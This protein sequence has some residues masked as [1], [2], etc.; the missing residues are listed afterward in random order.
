MRR[1]APKNVVRLALLP[2]LGCLVLGV[3]GCASYPTLPQEDR[4]AL[5]RQLT[6]RQRDR[7]LRLSFYVTP[8]FGDATKKLLT[9]AP[10]EDVRLLEQPNGEAIN[11]GPVEAIL[12]AGTR[13][14]ITKVEFPTAWSVAER[15]LYT[16]RTQP[17]IYLQTA[18]RGDTA[19]LILVLRAQIRS[20]EEFIAELERYLSQQD[21]SPSLARWSDVVQQAI[22]TKTAIIDMPA[23]ALE[24][25]W[26]YPER[27]RISFVDSAKNEEWIYV[28]DRRRA[29]LSD[30]RVVRLET[31]KDR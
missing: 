22:R 17:W 6:S 12:P 2:I 11:P 29:F 31:G 21:V 1:M 30:G 5:S 18:R 19:P 25:A 20:S 24:M 9:P 7:F 10:P 27:K 3:I 23:E 28:G 8:F 26:G 14:E 16:P 15:L 13:V 4:G